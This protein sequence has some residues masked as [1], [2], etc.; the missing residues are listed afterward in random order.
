MEEEDQ[1]LKHVCKFCNKRF[2]CG[3]SLGGHMRSHLII[4]SSKIDEKINKKKPSSANNGGSNNACAGTGTEGDFPGI[5]GLRENPKKNF[6]FADS[7]GESFIHN[8]LCKECGK[9]FQSWKALFGHM[10]C[11]SEKLSNNVEEEDSWAAAAAVVDTQSDN[12]ETAAPN[13]KKRSRRGSVTV[14]KMTATVAPTATSS[15]SMANNASSSVSEIDQQEQEEV[16]MCLMM[17]SKDFGCKGS[18]LDSVSESSNNNFELLEVKSSS[19]RSNRSNSGKNSWFSDGGEAVKFKKLRNGELES[20]I[21]DSNSQFEK[22]QSG[23]GASALSRN[24]SKMN[25]FNSDLHDDELDKSKKFRVVNESGFEASEDELGKNLMKGNGQNRAEFNSKSVELGVEDSDKKNKKSPFECTTC[26][27]TFPSYQALGGHRASHKKI[28]G[29]FASSRIDIGE[30]CGETEISPDPTA[31]ST[32]A[33]GGTTKQEVVAVGREKDDRSSL[34]KKNKVHECPIC[35]K[36]FLSGQ[37]LGGHKRSHLIGGSEAKSNHHHR[38]PKAVVVHKPIPEI[39]DLLDLN[40]P[41]PVEE[42]SSGHAGFKPWW[43]ASNGEH[44]PFLGLISN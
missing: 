41:A 1:E 20:I 5:Y 43:V 15:F 39:R 38:H 24:G 31:D 9:G 37:A 44:E 6:R 19:I 14:K 8:K 3:R 25:K 36:V 42:E 13:R 35:F 16:A 10:K 4:N 40:L 33:N 21:L 12:N 32:A 23:F 34:T 26:N 7:N 18:V 29:L 11:H 22:K 27:K 2:L 30:N 17:L 28:K